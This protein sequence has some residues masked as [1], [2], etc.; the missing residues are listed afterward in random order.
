MNKFKPHERK[1]VHILTSYFIF[2]VISILH[3]WNS[4]QPYTDF[5]TGTGDEEGLSGPVELPPGAD[6]DDEIQ[7]D[8]SGGGGGLQTAAVVAESD[9]FLIEQSENE[10]KKV[11]FKSP[12]RGHHLVMRGFIFSIFRTNSTTVIARK[13]LITKDQDIRCANSV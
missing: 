10:C 13:F 7:D 1:F 5:I 11:C 8:D 4:R 12:T 6:D 3:W 9:N 2:T